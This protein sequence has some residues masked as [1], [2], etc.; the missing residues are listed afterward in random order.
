[1]HHCR[2]GYA[3]RGRTGR[4]GSRTTSAPWGCLPHRDL[5]PKQLQEVKRSANVSASTGIVVRGQSAALLEARSGRLTGAPCAHW[6]RPTPV[7]LEEALARLPDNTPP[8]LASRQQSSCILPASLEVRQALRWNP[9][10]R[11][12]LRSGWDGRQMTTGYISRPTVRSRS[13]LVSDAHP[14]SILETDE[15][16]AKQHARRVQEK[17][18]V[19]EG[20]IFLP[21]QT[22][23]NNEDSDMPAPFRQRRYFYYMTGCVDKDDAM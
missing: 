12:A 13:I 17:L 6:A 3:W 10:M 21:G 4:G 18:G 7:S 15:N 23:R 16:S 20:L 1:M 2:T 14:L 19:E 11:L 5:R 8:R 9:L 22:A